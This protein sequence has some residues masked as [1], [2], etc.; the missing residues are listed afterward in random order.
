MNATQC[1]TRWMGVG[2]IALVLAGCSGEPGP[3]TGAGVATGAFTGALIGAATGRSPGSA[4]AGA[5]IGGVVGGAIG[6]ALDE[7]DRRR[8][9]EAE[10]NALE[11]GG[12]GNPVSWRG[13]RDAYGTI[14]VGPTYPQ[15]NYS[16]CRQYT[17]TIYIHGRP[18]AARGVACRNPDG[19]WTRIS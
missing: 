7:E 16:R 11:Y 6:N 19:T 5:L 17:H 1:A 15:S 18:E 13:E 9:Y 8:A 4:V 12:P 3:K 14:V 2:L 10:M